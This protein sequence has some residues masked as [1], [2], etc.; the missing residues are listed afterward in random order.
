[1]STWGCWS[2]Q[3]QTE[4]ARYPGDL[5]PGSGDC[6]KSLRW[7]KSQDKWKPLSAVG[8]KRRRISGAGSIHHEDN[9]PSSGSWKR[10]CR[11]MR[12]GENKKKRP[13]NCSKFEKILD[14]LQTWN[15][16]Y[17]TGNK[18]PIRCFWKLHFSLFCSFTCFGGA[19]T[20][21]RCVKRSNACLFICMMVI[22]ITLTN[23]SKH[24]IGYS[25]P[26]N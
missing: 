10:V 17:L 23:V 18:H 14:A 11:R 7:D 26:V 5:S 19:S 3:I 8:K 25:W 13:A 12:Q 9:H 15:T 24:V 20:F 21:H 1:M 2:G 4:A 22:V 6:A 16:H